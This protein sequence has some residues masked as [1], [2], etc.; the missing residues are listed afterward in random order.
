MILLPPNPPNIEYSRYSIAYDNGEDL[1][2]R[3]GEGLM[4]GRED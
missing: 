1:I 4:L 3:V 2:L